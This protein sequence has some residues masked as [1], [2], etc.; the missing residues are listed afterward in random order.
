MRY[1]ASPLRP[2]PIAGLIVSI[3]L[4]LLLLY[5]QTPTLALDFG[6]IYVVLLI[7]ALPAVLLSGRKIVMA[8]YV[9]GAVLFGAAVFLSSAPIL[10]AK[11]YY[12]MLGTETPANFHDTL[13]PIDIEQAPLVSQDMALQAMQKRLSEIASLGSQVAVGTPVKQLVRGKLVWVAF[14]EHSGFFKW[15]ADGA[16]PGYLVV[17]AHD[18]A[19]VQLVMQLDGKPLK[20][21]Y[22]QS[23]YFGDAVERHA[24]LSGHSTIGLTDFEPELD[25]NGV[26][27]YVGTVYAHKVG[28]SGSESTGIVTVNAVSGEV[29]RYPLG[30]E[31][32]WVDRIQ[33]EEFI[34]EQMRD[35]GEYIH[36]FINL[37]NDGRLRVEGVLDLVYGSDQRPYWVGGMT[38]KGQNNGLSGFYFVD[39]RTKAVRWF[40]V[41]SV[42][43][44]T[45]AH[46]VENVNPEKHYRSTNPL[47]FLVGG[48]PTYVMALRDTQ[49][50]SRA[51]GMVDMRN[52]QVIGVADTLSATLRSYQS[53]R[54]TNRVAADI[55]TEA[56]EVALKGT[57][58]RIASEFRNNQTMYYITL[59]QSA[60]TIFTGSSDLS[61]E[62]VLTRP[63]DKVELSY[64]DSN[65][66][67]V[68]MSKFH[69]TDIPAR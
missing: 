54:S 27:Y 36:G 16:T 21:R 68:G 12:N 20:L 4:L 6:G 10:H 57:V 67:V 33:A 25:D 26:P 34:L 17:S 65:T 58:V 18:P 37:N 56:R 3:L 14:L 69:N 9:A 8:A 39:S 41:P 11:A 7:A 44:A 38:S 19:D 46:A 30:T 53:R 31:P 2:A 13:P 35:R 47:P 23:A 51:F 48:A 43:Q 45:A 40:K 55:G 50:V 61:E 1:S 63:G 62:L 49:G 28:F 42:S 15:F 32:A 66:R 60:G 22:L 64:A 5:S 52:N 24:Y 59:D 29:V